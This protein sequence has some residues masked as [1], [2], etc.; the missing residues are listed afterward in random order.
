MDKFCFTSLVND[1]SSFLLRGHMSL[2]QPPASPGMKPAPP[3]RLRPL[4]FGDGILQATRNFT[5]SSARGCWRGVRWRM[6]L[7]ICSRSGRGCHQAAPAGCV[8]RACTEK[9]AFVCCGYLMCWPDASVDCSNRCACA[10]SGNLAWWCV[11]RA[12]VP[13]SPHHPKRIF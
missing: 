10:F 6:S 9:E 3:P 11:L 12:A 5:K 13:A 1:V 4:L 2:P 7:L 8:V